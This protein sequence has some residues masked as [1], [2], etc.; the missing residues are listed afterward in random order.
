MYRIGGM[1]HSIEEQESTI[2]KQEHTIAQSI[3]QKEQVIA[4]KEQVIAEN[5][6]KIHNLEASLEKFNVPACYD[7]DTHT[8]LKQFA[9]SCSGYLQVSSQDACCEKRK[10]AGLAGSMRL[11]QQPA[12]Y[13]PRGCPKDVRRH[14]TDLS[15]WLKRQNTALQG[16]LS[17]FS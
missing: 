14:T 8:C 2:T 7:N 10:A 12:D 1:Y 17:K 5:Q 13:E 11:F 4:Q 15:D 6:N 9:G 3:A 16:S